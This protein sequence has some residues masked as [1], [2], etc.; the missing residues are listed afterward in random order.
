MRS[1]KFVVAALVVGV[2]I[3]AGASARTDAD[4]HAAR[5]LDVPK[6]LAKKIPSVRTKS[7]L[8][9]LLPDTIGIGSTKAS[10]IYP[11]SF[12]E[13]GQYALDL[14]AAKHCG[15]ATACF[16][17]EFTGAA[18]GEVGYTKKVKL[19]GGLT[20]YYKPLTCGGSC[21]PPAIEW[22]IANV[23]YGIQYNYQG[24][25]ATKAKKALIKLAN[26]ANAAG[27]R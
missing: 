14:G 6:A 18:G 13:D 10:K 21:S 1:A 24:S 19:A 5:S 11:D 22:K 20:G 27:A 2:L 3:P 23:V 12:A 7:G 8:N 9:V 16:V 25:N 4:V 26:Q 17:A 15:G